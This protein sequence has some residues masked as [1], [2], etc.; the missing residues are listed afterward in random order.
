MYTAEN[1]VSVS[2]TVPDLKGMSLSQAKNALKAQNLN[3]NYT[4]SGVVISQDEVAGSQIE[5]GS[6][7][8]VILQEE[9]V[10]TY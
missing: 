2:T 8:N 6:I 4:G 7:I 3:I 5:S 10:D 9:G 1:T